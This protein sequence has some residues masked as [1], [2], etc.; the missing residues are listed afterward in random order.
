MRLPRLKSREMAREVNEPST[1]RSA[2]AVRAEGGRR[3]INRCGGFDWIAYFL[4]FAVEIFFAIV[5]LRIP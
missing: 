2:S 3:L 4:G 5:S 1:R